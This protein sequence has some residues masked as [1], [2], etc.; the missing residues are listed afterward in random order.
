MS[1][2]EDIAEGYCCPP[3]TVCYGC[4]SHFSHV[5]EW[6]CFYCRSAKPLDPIESGLVDMY[7]GRVASM[8]DWR[9]YDLFCAQAGIHH[10]E[11]F[12]DWPVDV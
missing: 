10:D 1:D 5:E 11:G 12:P 8:E 3:W 2:R 9:M 7:L 4:R 6:V